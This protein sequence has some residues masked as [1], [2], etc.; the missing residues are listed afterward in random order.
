MPT[1]QIRGVG[2]TR[3]LE[4]VWIILAAAVL[5]SC[6]TTTE[7]G[8]QRAVE[9]APPVHLENWQKMKECAAQAEKTRGKDNSDENMEEGRVN[10]YSPKYDR[11]FIRVVHVARNAKV[12]AGGFFERTTSTLLLDAFEGSIGAMVPFAGPCYLGG[13]EAN[14]AKAEEFIAD[15]MAN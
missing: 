7:K 5:S 2:F 1:G 13:K 12:K 14:C 3:C 11:C 10:H 15:A 8:T 6:Q 9:S 4:A